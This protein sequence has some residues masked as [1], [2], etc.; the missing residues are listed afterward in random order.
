MQFISIYYVS[1]A[2][3]IDFKVF[4]QSEKHPLRTTACWG[5]DANLDRRKTWGLHFL[6]PRLLLSLC[7]RW[8][9]LCCNMSHWPRP[10]LP[11]EAQCHPCLFNQWCMPLEAVRGCTCVHHTSLPQALSTQN[12]ATACMCCSSKKR[13]LFDP[14]W[15]ILLMPFSLEIKQLFECVLWTSIQRK[16]WYSWGCAHVYSFS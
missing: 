10:R 15:R 3:P 8:Y 1:V 5:A 11:T 9:W 14:S 6:S 12:K 13:F 16:L 7:W 2:H 4:P